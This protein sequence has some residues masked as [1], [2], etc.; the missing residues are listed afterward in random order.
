M[1]S[2][3]KKLARLPASRPE[4]TETGRSL[5]LFMA[6]WDRVTNRL[7]PSG[8]LLLIIFFAVKSLAGDASEELIVKEIFFGSTTGKPYVG[9]F[10][11]VLAL[12]TLIDSSLIYR[13]I[14][15]ERREMKRLRAENR[16]LQNKLLEL[17]D[18]QSDEE[19]AS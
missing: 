17:Q 16:R 2:Q 12:F 19:Q 5:G 15:G 6:V 3:T 1:G 8:G 18:H 14:K 10:F 11:A 13:Y 7:G 4:K 9:I